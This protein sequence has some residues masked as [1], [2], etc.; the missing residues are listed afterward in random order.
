MPKI[1]RLTHLLLLSALLLSACNLPSSNTDAT[2]SG[3]MVRTAAAE[4]VQALQTQIAA[5]LP[6][7]QSAA[8]QESATEAPTAKVVTATPQPLLPSL[9]PLVVTSAPTAVPTPCDRAS[10]VSDV[11][12]PDG[13]KLDPGSSF[14]KTWR[15]QNNGTC[16]WSNAYKLVFASGDAMSGP[17]SQAL[18]GN[19]A[20]GQSVDLSVNL[21]APTTAGSYQGNWKLQNA[22]G[23]N[24]GVGSKADQPFWVKITVGGT[25]VPSYFA[26]T[27]VTTTQKV[28]GDAC[29]K[30]VTFTA[31][32][33]TSKAGVV[34]YQWQRSDGA[35]GETKSLEFTEGGTKSVTT[36]WELGAAGSGTMT[37]WEQI[38]IDNPNHQLFPKAQFSFECP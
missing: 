35:T 28:T 5:T 22:S 12:I 25:S 20:P 2:P 8:T 26:V 18:P 13:T 29:P 37:G 17:A 4:T 34:T 19:V 10:F 27:G 30:K 36:T 16:T 9:T 32:I 21:K 1:F 7:T 24:F 31:N 3:D 14:T 6:S 38:Y 15:L 23:Q 33:S 11:T